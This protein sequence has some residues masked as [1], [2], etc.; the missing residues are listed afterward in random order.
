[1]AITNCLS[2]IKE[3]FNFFS[4]RQIKSGADLKEGE[5]AST[6]LTPRFMPYRNTLLLNPSKSQ[7]YIFKKSQTLFDPLNDDT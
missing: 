6:E 4:A 7:I 1:M 2:K 3:L 5:L